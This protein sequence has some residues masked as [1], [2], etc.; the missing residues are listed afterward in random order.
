MDVGKLTVQVRSGTGK[1]VARKLRTQGLVPGI[2]YGNEIEGAL[3]IVV[4]PKA[5]KRALD[6]EKRHNT[7]ITV[8]VEG[9]GG[10]TLTAMLKEY[11][12]HPIRQAVT[13]VDLVAIDP[14]KP[15]NVEVPIVYTGKAAG[16]V[17]GGQLHIVMRSISVRCKPA[18]IP[19]KFELDVSPLK[20]GDALHVSDVTP[21]AGVEVV[22]AASL[23]VVTVTVPVEEKVEAP[24][25]VE[26]A[27]GAVAA[28]GAAP[29]EGA[30]GAAAAPGA[31]PGAPGAAG[32]K[33][34]APAVTPD[35]KAAKD[36][37]RAQAKADKGGKK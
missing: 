17:D 35:A 22:D 7:V 10:R 31:A 37:A 8:T 9:P 4:D 11:Q 25:V 28:E 15:V 13:H 12:V 2:C 36:L 19:V 23:A 20:I 21:P 32:A 5:L 29:A 27:E 24:A 26:G 30:E 33:P 6:P 14:N 34:G 16:L 18:D 1:G 3:P